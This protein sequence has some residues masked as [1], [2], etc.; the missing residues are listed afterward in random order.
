MDPLG[1]HRRVRNQGLVDRDRQRSGHL[2]QRH[3]VSW[4]ECDLS[5][6]EGQDARCRLQVF[7]RIAGHAADPR[8]GQGNCK[9]SRRRRTTGRP[10]WLWRQRRSPGP[11]PSPAGA[12][13]TLGG[14]PF[15]RGAN[16]VR[17][18][19]ACTFGNPRRPE[20]PILAVAHLPGRATVR[21][22]CL[23]GSPLSLLIPIQYVWG[24]IG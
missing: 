20:N 7:V 1:L 22:G 15:R 3:H 2:S 12:P 10:I 8:K 23:G 21:S 9:S 18:P 13:G 4:E 16:G 24:T 11:D 5:G 14:H 6:P 17:G 19:A